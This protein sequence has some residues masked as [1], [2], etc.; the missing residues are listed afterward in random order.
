MSANGTGNISTRAGEESGGPLM[1]TGIFI[2]VGAQHI[3]G[4]AKSS[5]SYYPDPTHP[6]GWH[7]TH[8]G[9]PFPHFF[10]LGTRPR[11][12]GWIRDGEARLESVIQVL[13][14]N[15]S[16]I[17]GCNHLRTLDLIRLPQAGESRARELF[18]A[19]E[20]ELREGIFV[21]TETAG[22]VRSSVD[23]A[24]RLHWGVV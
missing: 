23:T 3:S 1:H 7:P 24:L 19:L 11:S 5:V 22:K 4:S 18:R 15:L 8:H 14:A 2:G 12:M 6:K 17:R 10:P 20:S 9:R 13:E 16:D 21:R